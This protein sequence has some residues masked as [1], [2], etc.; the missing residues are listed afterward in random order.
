MNTL[1]ALTPFKL[2]WWTAVNAD[3]ISHLKRSRSFKCSKEDEGNLK[4]KQSCEYQPWLRLLICLEDISVHQ[5]YPLS[6]ILSSSKNVHRCE[7]KVYLCICGWC[8]QMQLEHSKQI[9]AFLC[10]IGL[11]KSKAI[12]KQLCN[13]DA[14]NWYRTAGRKYTQ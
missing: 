5:N 14:Y 7:W 1:P 4:G 3:R 2:N 10:V 11:S 8:L 6:A 12:S 9:I 13:S